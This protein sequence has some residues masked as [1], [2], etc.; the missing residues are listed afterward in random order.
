[1][2][3]VRSCGRQKRAKSR[4]MG[5]SSSP[6]AVAARGVGRGIEP[7][8]TSRKWPKTVRYAVAQRR[9]YPPCNPVAPHKPASFSERNKLIAPPHFGARTISGAGQHTVQNQIGNAVGTLLRRKGKMRNLLNGRLEGG[10]Q[11]NV[12]PQISYHRFIVQTKRPK[13]CEDVG[14]AKSVHVFSLLTSLARPNSSAS[15]A[16]AV[17]LSLD[18]T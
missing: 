8:R 4:T 7:R 15:I 16:K 17:S 10:R 2:T 5:V 6:I 12:S 1:M 14:D 9:V 13:R 11:A 18:R 3:Y